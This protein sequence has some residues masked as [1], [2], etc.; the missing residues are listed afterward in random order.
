M[1]SNASN[2]GNTISLVLLTKAGQRI[3]NKFCGYA[4]LQVKTARK[5]VNQTKFLHGHRSSEPEALAIFLVRVANRNV[6][7][8]RHTFRHQERIPL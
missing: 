7:L 5:I 2:T 8:L 4:N 6:P 3:L 1:L